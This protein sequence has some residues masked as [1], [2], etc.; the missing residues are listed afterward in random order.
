M[1]D[2]S[3]LHRPAAGHTRGAKERLR[4]DELISFGPG[5]GGIVRMPATASAQNPAPLLVVC[6]ERYGLVQH[7]VDIVDRFAEAGWAAVS[8]DFYLG[9]PDDEASSLPALTDDVVLAHIDAALLHM[10]QD[11]RCDTEKVVVFGVCRSG[12]WGLLASAA[13]P[14]VCGVI[15]L[16]GGASKRDFTISPE[17]TR[18]YREIIRAAGA[19]VLGIFG[20]RDHTMSVD[21][22]R[23]LRDEFEDA[24]RSYDLSIVPAMPHGWLNDTMPGRFRGDVAEDTWSRMLS[25]LAAVRSDSFLPKGQV[26][27][28]FASRIDES[29]DFSSNKRL[30]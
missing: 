19:P 5:F 29:Y 3:P 11:P 27:W 6:P 15:M 12:S 21:D 10:R 17:R 2:S 1:C 9:M 16:Y 22:V 7:T 13:H 30:E 24:R 8:P 4:E 28:A 14:T 18:D 26:Q 20:E 23:R 25:F